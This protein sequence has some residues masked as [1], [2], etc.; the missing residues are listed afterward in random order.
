M[1]TTTSE[2]IK[3]INV[4]SASLFLILLLCA[5]FVFIGLHAVNTLTPLLK[6]ALYSLG[7]DSSYSEMF[8]YLKWLWIIILLAYVS[9]SRRSFGYLAW[10]LLFVYFLCDDALSI[11]EKVGE[12]IAG[13]LTLTPPFGLGLQDLGEL[14]VSAVAGM[15]LFS[16]VT[17]AYLQGS[18][19][20]RKVSQDLLLLILALVFFGVF[21]DMVHA[22]IHSGWRADFVLVVIEDGGEMLVASV[23]LWYVFL[24]SLRDEN[25]SAYLCDILRAA[26][27]RRPT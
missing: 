19:V 7:S 25:A 12:H 11:H 27:T 18:Q 22:A 8:Q 23:I 1:Q 16:F 6:S 24:L 4:P 20:F 15:V 26:L 17:W 9:R 21:V 14:L 13:Y 2:A 10:L 3:K 5:D